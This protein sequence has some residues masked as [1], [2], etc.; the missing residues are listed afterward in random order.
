MA[1]SPL[2]MGGVFLVGTGM[3]FILSGAEN[4]AE[5]RRQQK[6]QIKKPVKGQAEISGDTAV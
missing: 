4:S 1:A 6:I 5:G 3:P 2:G